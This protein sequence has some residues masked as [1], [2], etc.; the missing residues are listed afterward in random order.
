MFSFPAE[1]Q[2]GEPCLPLLYSN[3]NSCCCF[4]GTQRKVA[5]QWEGQIIFEMHFMLN[6]ECCPVFLGHVNNIL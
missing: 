6:Q 4:C 2:N 5:A 3:F 1:I